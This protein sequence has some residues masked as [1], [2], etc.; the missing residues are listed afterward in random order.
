MHLGD[1]PLTGARLND[2]PDGAGPGQEVGRKIFCWS[3]AD[4][5]VTVVL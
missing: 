5:G 4:T 2:S 3:A 1:G